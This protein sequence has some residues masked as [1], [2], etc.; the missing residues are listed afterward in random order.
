M[1]DVF[2]LTLLQGFYLWGF[3]FAFLCKTLA[4]LAENHKPEVLCICSGR[5]ENFQCFMPQIK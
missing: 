2:L 5:L 4:D 1:Y 3:E